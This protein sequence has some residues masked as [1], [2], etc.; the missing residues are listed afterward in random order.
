[1]LRHDYAALKGRYQESLHNDTAIDYL[2]RVGFRQQVRLELVLADSD[3]KYCALGGG[4]K[5]KNRWAG[6]EL[7]PY[8][9]GKTLDPNLLYKY[10]GHDVIADPNSPATR[11]YMPMHFIANKLSVKYLRDLANCHGA[12]FNS[13]TTRKT[14]AAFLQDLTCHEYHETLFE[15]LSNTSNTNGGRTPKT[16]PSRVPKHKGRKSRA[17]PISE[18]D[19]WGEATARG[20]ATIPVLESP[21]IY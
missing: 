10:V 17:I 9:I 6:T 19:L 12:K 15:P 8:V 14:A 18:D 3:T 11:Y 13:R 16:Q 21:G 1:M 7:N 4:G 20:M 2:Y 5:P